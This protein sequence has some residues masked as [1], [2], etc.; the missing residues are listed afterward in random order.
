MSIPSRRRYSQGER[1]ELGLM[2]DVRTK[3]TWT[4]AAFEQSLGLCVR[5]ATKRL[6]RG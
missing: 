2:V 4:V 6:S 1:V 5:A 3:G